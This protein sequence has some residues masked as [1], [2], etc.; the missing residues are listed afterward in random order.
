MR[1]IGLNT[2]SALDRHIV[3]QFYKDPNRV[4]SITKIA[5]SSIKARYCKSQKQ[6]SQA[7]DRLVRDGL[8]VFKPVTARL[9]D[10][11]M[12]EVPAGFR[13]DKTNLDS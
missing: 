10:G 5:H 3:D 8:L 6:V 13:L 11:S 4:L 9:V 12:V 1:K 7:I 2:A